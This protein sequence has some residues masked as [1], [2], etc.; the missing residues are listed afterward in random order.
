MSNYPLFQ[1]Q[2]LEECEEEPFSYP[3]GP[4]PFL[5][6][7]SFAFFCL[8]SSLSFSC[9]Q[10]NK[11]LPCNIFCEWMKILFFIIWIYTYGN[12]KILT[13]TPKIRIINFNYNLI[14][15]AASVLLLHRSIELN[16][17]EF[18]DWISNIKEKFLIWHIFN[19]KLV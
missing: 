11:C 18:I 2:P 10:A 4:F 19:V 17:P 5:S 16:V 15:S 12:F 6:L 3:G 9:M 8:S 14:Y 1:F 13:R 7:S